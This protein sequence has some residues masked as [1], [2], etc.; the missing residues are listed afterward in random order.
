MHARTIEM[1]ESTDERRRKG[2]SH[3]FVGDLWKKFRCVLDG[4]SKAQN[5]I[6]KRPRY[7]SQFVN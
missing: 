5:S 6:Q 7:F 2:S 1:A 4:A 3:C